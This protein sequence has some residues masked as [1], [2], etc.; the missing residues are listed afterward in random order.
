MVDNVSSAT[1]VSPDIQQILDQ[2][3]ADMDA[4]NK[5][6]KDLKKLA[7]GIKNT[8]NV[9]LEVIEVFGLYGD[10]QGGQ[11]K[12]LSDVDNLDSTL[13]SKISAAQSDSNDMQNGGTSQTQDMINEVQQI[14]NF[15][16]F[17]KGKGD[18][19]ILDQTSLANLKSAIEQI[20]GNYGNDWGNASKMDND[21]S[22]WIAQLNSGTN[23]PQLKNLQDGFQTVN[24]SV[25]QFSASTNT[26]LQYVENQYKQRLGEEN[27]AMQSYQ[28]MNS[29]T[30]R[31][32][33]SS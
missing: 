6:L 5:M 9:M 25:S 2:Y 32:F 24:Q 31:H 13:R 4:Y 16:Q 11:I 17:E 22:G 7:A 21:M 3:Q 23:V 19:S 20:K 10:S 29:N 1:Q 28:K 30:I 26:S 18:D 12:T 33:T 8:G 14:E 15:I 27:S